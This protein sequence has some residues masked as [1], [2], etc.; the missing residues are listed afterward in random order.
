MASTRL[1]TLK[2]IALLAFISL[3]SCT[4]YNYI[5]GGVASGVHDCSMWEYLEQQT[6]DWDSTRIMIEHAGMKS[7]F[8][9]S[10]QYKDITFLGITDLSI[11]R[12]ML[13]HNAKVDYDKEHGIEV[14]PEDYWHR[15]KDIPKEQCVKV[16]EQLIIPQRFMLKDIPQGTRLKTADGAEY[17][18]TGGKVFT[19]L[20]GNLFIWME[21]E[22]YAGVED[23]GAK[24]LYIARQVNT[25]ENWRVASTDIQTTT[26]VVHALGYDFKI[27]NF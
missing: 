15:V 20:S 26:G 16:L 24:N 4:K 11:V 12:Y 1:N 5:D 7:I 27:I 3:C 23:A 6:V 2:G 14:S 21:P 19:A 10:G 17:V 25:G 8:D 9:G 22:D 13:D 18:E